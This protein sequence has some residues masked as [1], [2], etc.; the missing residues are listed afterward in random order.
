VTIWDIGGVNLWETMR[1]LRLPGCLGKERAKGKMQAGSAGGR[2]TA[3]AGPGRPGALLA[4]RLRAMPAAPAGLMPWAPVALAF[5]IG[6]W[7]LL[8]E[9]PGLTAALLCGA[10]LMAA[11]VLARLAEPAARLP[12]AVLALVAAGM[13]LM[14]LRAFTVSAPVLPWRYYGPV[15]GRVIAIDRSFSDALRVTLDQVA[16]P[17]LTD[18]PPP[19]RVRIALRGKDPG[20]TPLPGQRLRLTAH[21]APPDGPVEPGSFDF[22]RLAW[23]ARL[24][25]VGYTQAPA[26]ELAAP[27]RHDW[28]LLAARMRMAISRRMQEGMGGGQAAAEIAFAQ[29]HCAHHGGNQ[30]AYLAQRGRVEDRR[31]LHGHQYKDVGQLTE[32]T[33]ADD[34]GLVLT[35]QPHDLRPQP[36]PNWQQQQGAHR[37]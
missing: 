15:E 9:E 2:W 16:M 29:Q 24:G 6:P 4:A 26:V 25:G 35:P 10:A 8:H 1:T 34:L 33:D 22:Q 32:E 28:R 14:L 7:F 31:G 5:G 3:A 17:E 11:L 13:L 23:F 20:A 36:Q 37:H 19:E 21:V 27:D 18:A 12:A 30:N